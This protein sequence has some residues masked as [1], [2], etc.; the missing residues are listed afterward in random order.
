M[1]WTEK[2]QRRWKAKSIFQVM[3]ILTVF[4]FTGTTVTFLAKP[5]LEFL[6]A[7]ATIPLWAK[8]VYFILVLPIYN[9]FL[10]VYGLAFGQFRFFWNFEKRFFGRIFSRKRITDPLPYEK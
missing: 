8:I 9:V 5:I 4:A 6:F 1:N 10:L 7:P 3:V 2:L